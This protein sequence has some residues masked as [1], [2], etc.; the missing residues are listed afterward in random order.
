MEIAVLLG[1]AGFDSQKRTING[2]LDGAIPDGGNVYIFAGEGW[3]YEEQSAYETGEYHIYRLV[4]FSNYDGVLVNLDTIHDSGAVDGIM[5]GVRNAGVPCVSLNMEWDGAVCI[6]MENEKG[7][8]ALTEHLITKHQVKKITYLSGPCDNQDAKERLAAFRETMAKHGMAWKEEETLYGDYTYESGMEAAEELLRRGGGLPDAVMAANDEM[9]IGMILKLREQG[10]RVPEDVLVTG[11]DDS[12]TARVNYP[13]L[14]TVRRGESA[15]AAKAY[16]KLCQMAEK[17]TVQTDDVV[18]GSPVFGGSCGCVRRHDYTHAMLQE[19]YVR[20]VVQTEYYLKL[21]KNSAAEFTGLETFEDFM[22]VAKSYIRRIDP[23][24][25]YL[26]MC[27][28]IENYYDELE[29][30][31]EGQER[32][33]DASVY[34]E[35]IWIPIAYENGVF[36]S[37][38][39]FPKN[40]LLPEECRKGKQGN[41]YVVMPLHHQDYCFGYCVVG[42]YRPAIENR[43]FQQFVLNLN[44]ALETVRR[45]DTMRAMLGRLNRMWIL[46]ELTGVHNRA[47]LRKF[48][49]RV[50]EE[51]RRKGVPAAAIFVDVDGLKK[52]NDQYGHDEGDGLIKAIAGILEQTRQH[53][54]LLVRYGGD[55][56]LMLAVGYAEEDVREHIAG[57]HA[58]IQNY[59]M[60][61]HKKYLLDASIG[62]YV[63]PETDKQE[64][65]RMIELADQDMYRVKREKKARKTRDEKEAE[66][67]RK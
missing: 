26:C 22:R 32:G 54:Q 24:Y 46:D 56:F 50:L 31:A 27:G 23:Q 63:E 45:Q 62:Y 44:N 6:K 67:K 16:Q 21:I 57:I 35:D 42:N 29:R 2:V 3:S 34:K 17:K 15:A 38:D 58:S 5:Q 47:G 10:Y 11:Y 37:Y 19:K 59:N 64:L 18:Y 60:I 25:F 51:A 48:G 7:V 33:R 1:G 28:S 65:S 66:E 14:T 13:R 53:G 9:A 30:M 8:C 55:E 52:V 43:F 40:D 49:P 12:S 20:K 39:G 4:D 41:F 36:G 61:Y